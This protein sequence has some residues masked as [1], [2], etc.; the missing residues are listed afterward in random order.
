MSDPF[1]QRVRAAAVAGWWTVLVF[2][3]LL[4]LS[5]LCWTAM[6]AGQPDW[7][8]RFW[9]GWPDIT[10]EF[11]Q[12]TTIIAFAVFKGILYVAAMVALWLTLWA[13]RLA[14]AQPGQGE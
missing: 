4:T 6:N 12:R 9:G 10:W 2:G 1:V 11:I 8:L 3:V 7:M 14:R 13:W 5:W